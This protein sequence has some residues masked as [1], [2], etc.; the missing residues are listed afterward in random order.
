M[1]E[2]PAPGP[3]PEEP[4]PARER[5]EIW[6]RLTGLSPGD[7]ISLTAL[8]LSLMSIGWQIRDAWIGS[9]LTLLDLTGRPVEIRCSDTGKDACWGSA[10][11]PASGN[12]A[13]VLPVFFANAGADGYSAVVSHVRVHVVVP[14][15]TDA[16]FDLIANN[17]WE[18]TQNDTGN[19]KPFTPILIPGN[20]ASGAEL[21][22]VPFTDKEAMLWATLAHDIL[23]EKVTQ[24][25][26]E[27]SAAIIG[28]DKPLS[29]TCTLDITEG[30]RQ[31]L[32]S[33]RD[34]RIDRPHLTGFCT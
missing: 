14:P 2:V 7:K 1:S 16:G 12:L 6:S 32:E 31:A 11:A 26:F 4:E 5:A 17:V 25:H 20:S 15:A 23:A 18:M 33:R 21:R 10:S 13:V 24:I 9:D 28:E 22:F 34:R 19:A 29:A 30:R 3:R 27:I 8:L